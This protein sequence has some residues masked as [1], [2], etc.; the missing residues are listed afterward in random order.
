MKSM[1]R[2]SACCAAA[3]LATSTCGVLA[4]DTPAAPPAPAEAAP[5][6][7][8]APAEAA[9]KPADATLEQRVFD[10]E[11]YFNNVAPGVDGDKKWNTK[12]A[13]AGPGHNGFMMIC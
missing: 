8:A 1:K 4:Q 3:I 5:A 6:P 2:L 11:T 10:L 7:T 9:D 12:I 13:V